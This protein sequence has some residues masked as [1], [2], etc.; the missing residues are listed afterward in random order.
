[1]EIK[2]LVYLVTNTANGKRY[3]GQTSQPLQ[4]RWN[5]HKS[6]IRTRGN[7]YLYNAILRHGSEVFKI[8]PLVVVSSKQE[9]DYYETRLIR[10][11]DLR[12][13]EKGYNLTLGGGGMLGFKLSD[14]TKRKMSEHIKTEEHCQNISL[15]KIGNKSRLGMRH[16]RE[17]RRKM[18]EVAKGR[19]FSEEHRRNLSLAR[20]KYLSSNQ[21]VKQGELNG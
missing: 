11:W 16:S 1:M 14:E 7:S 13:P 17:T 20:R 21:D 19:K 8:Q 18:S 15:S 6:R 2:M 4:K 10:L 12:N 5:R 9:M 3:V